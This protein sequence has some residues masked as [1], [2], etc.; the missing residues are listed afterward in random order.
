MQTILVTGGAGYIGSHTCIELIQ[1]GYR[2][3]II[4][5]FSNANPEVLNRIHQVT[6][7]HVECVKADVQDNNALEQMFSQYQISGV[8]HFAGFKAVGES[9][10]KP[11]HYYENNLG[12]TLCLLQA[13]EKAKVKRLVFSSSAT[14]YGTPAS[15]PMTEDM[16]FNA[17]NPYGKS[18]Q[19]VE[20]M[21]QDLPIADQQNQTSLPWQ[22]S[23]LRYFN[24]VG[25]HPSGHLGEDPQGM[26]NNLMPFISQ[27]A[28]GRREKLSVFGGDYDTPDGSGVRDYIHVVDLARGHVK[29]IDKLLAE[30]SGGFN[31]YNLGTGQGISVLQMV[32]AFI[33][34]NQVA[35]PYEIVARRPGDIGCYY[36][37]A[38]KAAAELGWSA[39]L[40]LEDMVKDTW[41]WQSQNPQGYESPKG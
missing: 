29:A 24:P 14:V 41:R 33:E 35:V 17:V 7:T 6:G 16:P 28:V 3:V 13:M 32:K 38:S 10:C 15:L 27:T 8:I 22:L 25:S 2:P 5:N 12:S 34:Q 23:V 26:P 20:Q 39:E 40:S 31:A 11:I 37:D 19:L 30:P 18:K 21:L 36:A 4:D 1:A 9:V